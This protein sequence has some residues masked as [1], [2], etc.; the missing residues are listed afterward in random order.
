MNPTSTN[1]ARAIFQ[2]TTKQLQNTTKQIQNTTRQIQNTTPLLMRSSFAA[3]A[4]FHKPSLEDDSKLL[5]SDEVVQVANKD[6]IIKVIM[7]MMMVM[8]IY[9]YYHYYVA[10]CRG[11]ADGWLRYRK[12]QSRKMN[13]QLYKLGCDA[14]LTVFSR[15]AC[16]HIWTLQT[17]LEHYR[18]EDPQN[19]I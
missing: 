17:R 19:M 1:A 10:Q 4:I 6:I 16:A 8:I 2:N 5:P 13:W 9:H 18:F 11:G 3:R 12:L 7:I 14:D 15:K